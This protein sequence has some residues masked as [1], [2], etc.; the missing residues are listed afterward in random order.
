MKSTKT[1][2]F[3]LNLKNI[4]PNVPN[5][6]D[7][8]YDA[9]CDDALIHFRNGTFY[10]DFDREAVSLEEAII[11]AIK[12][13]KS[14]FVDAEIAS[15]FPGDLVT[16]AEIAK[17]LGKT[18]QTV[19]LWIK[20]ERRKLFPQPIMRLTEKSLLWSWSEV[21]KWLYDNGIIKDLEF[22]ENAKLIANINAVLEECNHE[23]REFRQRL[24]KKM[25]YY[26]LNYHETNR[27]ARLMESEKD[28][29]TTMKS[30]NIEKKKR[31]K[32]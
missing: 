13:V 11:S 1:F 15:V 25:G 10:L 8:L 27:V 6:E 30:E 21:T 9:N 5:L 32:I 16:E 18:R 17:R 31:G 28:Y 19:S 23:T 12:N 26:N 4:N 2:K 7:R 14:A 20:G 24:I 3:T 29:T 22:V